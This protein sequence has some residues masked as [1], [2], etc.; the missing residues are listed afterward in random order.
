VVLEDQEDQVV[1]VD[2]ENFST[3]V[4]LREV[5]APVVTVLTTV[6]AQD[7]DLVKIHITLRLVVIVTTE[8]TTHVLAATVMVVMVQTLHTWSA[9]LPLALGISAGIGHTIAEA[10]VVAVDL[11]DLA[12]QEE[13]AVLAVE[14]KDIIN[15]LRTDLRV[16]VVVVVLAVLAEIAEAVADL[17]LV[18]EDL[19]DLEDKGVLVEQEVLAE[20]VALTV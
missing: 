1:M 9:V 19:E 14:D 13:L 12:D 11:E 15:Q 8:T 5:K 18:T 2:K 7:I 3:N 20:T 10:P 16:L 4:D 6:H 17:T